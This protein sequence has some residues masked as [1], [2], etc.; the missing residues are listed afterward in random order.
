MLKTTIIAILIILAVFLISPSV[1]AQDIGTGSG[2]NPLNTI[3]SQAGY[4]TVQGET[5]IDTFVGEIITLVL[6]FVGALFLGII[7][8][9]GFQWMSAGGNEEVVSKAKKKVTSSVI[10]LGIVTLAF[11]IS[12]AVFTFFYAQSGR[13]TSSPYTAPIGPCGE[14]SHCATNE[15][16][17][18]AFC[19]PA[20]DCT[21]PPNVG[22]PPNYACTAQGEQCIRY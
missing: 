13:S 3:T 15:I 11:I 14:N 7:V 22:C 2:A 8:F 9:A 4:K 6:G 5:F 19:V 21:N 18:D 20:P 17:Q 16:C 1:L 12:N 10:G